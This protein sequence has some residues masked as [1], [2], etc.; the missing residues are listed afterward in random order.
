VTDISAREKYT[1]LRKVDLLARLSDA[2]IW[3]LVRAGRWMRVPADTPV[4]R[5]GEPGRSL[6]FL[7]SGAAKVTKGGKLLGELG[8]GACFGEMAYIKAGGMPR[9]ATVETLSE[10]VLAEY[11]AES[12]ADT[13]L[14]CR[15][16][17]TSALLHFMVDRL[18]MANERLARGP[19]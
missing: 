12:L 4:V 3:E 16:Q 2:E 5:E 8:E 14:N 9:T 6:F 13:S 19:K 18:A 15:L 17:L 7:G 1:A 11:D 10:A